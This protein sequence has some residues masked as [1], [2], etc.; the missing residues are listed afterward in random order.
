MPLFFLS[1]QGNNSSWREKFGSRDD[2]VDCLGDENSTNPLHP[3]RA[4]VLSQ[5]GNIA[6]TS[7]KC[8]T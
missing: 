1:I 2:I 7:V 6:M 5:H 4:V 8:F 3:D